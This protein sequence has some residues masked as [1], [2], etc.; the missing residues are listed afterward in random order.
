MRTRPYRVLVHTA[1]LPVS[2]LGLGPKLGPARMP[3]TVLARGGPGSA[4]SGTFQARGYAMLRLK[5]G[6]VPI[7]TGMTV[8]RPVHCFSICCVR[9]HHV[10]IY[11][12]C[13]ITRWERTISSRCLRLELHL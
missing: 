5:R 10:R 1:Q 8:C 3:A 7:T 6:I 12:H 9:S 11:E 13:H 2:V 4:Q